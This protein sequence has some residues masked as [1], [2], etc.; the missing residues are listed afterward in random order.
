MFGHIFAAAGLEVIDLVTWL[1]GT[2]GAP[3][4]IGCLYKKTEIRSIPASLMLRAA[5]LVQARDW[6]W[7]SDQIALY[8]DP[9]HVGYYLLQRGAGH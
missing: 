7:D 3:G 6:L 9:D 8:E 1:R 4:V 5:A 2:L